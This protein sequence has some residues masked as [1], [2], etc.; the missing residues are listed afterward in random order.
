M[1]TGGCVLPFYFYSVKACVHQNVKS[2]DISAFLNKN[3]ITDYN[4]K[5][6]FV[7]V[8]CEWNDRQFISMQ[9]GVY[10]DDKLVSKLFISE[11]SL[12]DDN[13]NIQDSE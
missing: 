12:S 9:V 8:D 11:N 4:I 5:D 10:V 13:V 6:I 2:V 1:Y 3:I 7:T